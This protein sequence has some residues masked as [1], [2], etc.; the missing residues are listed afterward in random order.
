MYTPEKSRKSRPPLLEG[1]LPP[2]RARRQSGEPLLLQLTSATSVTSARA[3]KLACCVAAPAKDIEAAFQRH[4][5]QLHTS[6][7]CA[8]ASHDAKRP[9]LSPCLC[10]SAGPPGGPAALKVGPGSGLQALWSVGTPQL[11]SDVLAAGGQ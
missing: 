4:G 8:G 11:N 3:Q 10:S 9:C 5:E 7:G 2:R 6:F 1:H